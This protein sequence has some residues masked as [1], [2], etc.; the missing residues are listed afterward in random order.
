MM[1]VVHTYPLPGVVGCS[2]SRRFAGA[3]WFNEPRDA[4]PG[5]VT[6]VGVAGCRGAVSGP[7]RTGRIGRTL[8]SMA[9]QWMFRRV[10]FACRLGGGCATARSPNRGDGPCRIRRA[11]LVVELPLPC[12]RRNCSVPVVDDWRQTMAHGAVKWFNAEKGFGFITPD[13]G[14]PDVFVHFSAIQGGGYRSLEENQQV[15]YTVTQGT[16]GPQASDVT[17]A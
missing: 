1:R 11:G 12:P 3:G 14:G 6:R 13:G 10:G 15:S 5:L 9:G 2:P 17:S 4:R 7:G 16:K 8:R